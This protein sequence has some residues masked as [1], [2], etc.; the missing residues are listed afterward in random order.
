[1]GNLL[2]VAWLAL[3]SLAPPAATATEV[4]PLRHRVNDEAGLLTPATASALEDRL[5][6]QEAKTGNQLVV[7]I[8][9]NLGGE[10]IE[11]F[12]IR[13]ADAWKIGRKGK[14][15]GAILLVAR[16][17]RKL[18]I[19][20]GYGLEGQ[21]TDLVSGRIIRDIIS[22]RFKAGD[23][24]GG[25]TAGVDAMIQVASGMPLAAT[26]SRPA[27]ADGSVNMDDMP[28]WQRVLIVLGIDAFL[29]LFAFV[30]LTAA[31][32]LF[33]FLYLFLVPFFGVFGFIA[34]S[35]AGI[36]QL[37]GWLV[38]YPLARLAAGNTAWGRRRLAESSAARWGSR[39]TSDLDT[40]G[41]RMTGSRMQS[42]SSD[43]DD[44]FK[45][46]G[47]NFGGGGASGDW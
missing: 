6:G 42:S 12:G 1:M 28:I 32:P 45:G 41:A 13:V 17:E 31:R 44:S 30:G 27:R 33:I 22:P 5:A 26:Q 15:N 35:K 23:F 36:G 25:V 37:V 34:G 24:N 40:D 9:P 14:D 39:T 38:L 3:S 29:A 21:L 2:A 19:E 10:A 43:S 46:G 8:V 11:A 20:V 47:G 7:L 4:P 18:R 16:D